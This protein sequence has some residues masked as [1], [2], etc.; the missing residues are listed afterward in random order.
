MT[1]V[2]G[3]ETGTGRCSEFRTSGSAF[4]LPMATEYHTDVFQCPLFISLRGQTPPS[5]WDVSDRESPGVAPL[6]V[7]DALLVDWNLEVYA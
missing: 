7:P 4:S 2:G 6:P 3:F 1:A 5:V